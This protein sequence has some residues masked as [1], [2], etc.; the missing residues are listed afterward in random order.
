MSGRMPV[1]FVPHAG[2]PLGHVPMGV[3]PAEERAFVAYW[4]SLAT[5]PKVRPSAVVVVSAHWETAVPTVMSSAR[6]P[7]LYDYGGF[8]AEAYPIA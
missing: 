7:M 6:P 5:L 4:Q 3:A 1:A 8:P 2:G